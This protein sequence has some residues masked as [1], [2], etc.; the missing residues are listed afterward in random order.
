[1]TSRRREFGTPHALWS[2]GARKGQDTLRITFQESENA[3]VIRLE[4]RLAGPWAAELS[5]VWVE[6][7]PRLASRKLTI[8]LNNVTYADASGKQVLKAIC[9]ETDAELVA[10]TPLTQFIAQEVAA[11]NKPVVG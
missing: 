8:D 10:G 3:M 2:A 9:T 1:V 5:R 4:G 7:A 11:I 6:T